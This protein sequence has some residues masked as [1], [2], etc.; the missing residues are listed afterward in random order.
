MDFE[1]IVRTAGK[2]YLPL[3]ATILY[4]LKSSFA[5]LRRALTADFSWW[6]AKVQLGTRFRWLLRFH[7]ILQSEGTWSVIIIAYTYR[8][9]YIMMIIKKLRNFRSV[10]TWYRNWLGVSEILKF[11]YSEEMEKVMRQTSY[12]SFRLSVLQFRVIISLPTL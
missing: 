4:L 7:F 8:N 6:S 9:V 10:R 2:V 5:S 1:F 12:L 3:H 11:I